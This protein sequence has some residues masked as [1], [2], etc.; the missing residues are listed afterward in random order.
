MKQKLLYF[1][2]GKS[3]FVIKD[4]EILETKYDVREF[5]FDTTNKK[6]YFLQFIKQKLFLVSKIFGAKLIVC[7]FAGHYS[8]LPILFTKLFFKKSVIIAGGTDCVSFPSISYG[9]FSTKLMRFTTSFS[10][11]N[12]SLILPVHKTLVE[13]DYTYQPNDFPKQG[14]KYFIK[15]L[16]T[17]VEVIHNGYDNTKWYCDSIK[18]KISFVTIG[19]GLGSRF[20][21]SLKGIDLIFEIAQKFP[22]SI[23]YIVGGSSIKTNAPPNVKLLE[24][25]PNNQIQPLLSKMQF[26]MQLSLSEGFPNALSEAMLCECVPIVSNVGGMPDIVSDCGFVL[27]HKNIDELYSLIESAINNT[28]IS[29]IGKKA[30][31]RIEDNYTFE[32]RKNKLLSEL[33][34]L[35]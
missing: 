13:Y 29:V 35:V 16:K 3:S 9:N 17:N 20:G 33:Q 22:E 4:I 27:K 18:E 26:Y 14:F 28:D 6:K 31:K 25:M 11:K 15:D 7:Q 19:A 2:S 12:C 1:H 10:F 8:F 21:F 23:F 5:F 32:K 24:N 30:R 34:K